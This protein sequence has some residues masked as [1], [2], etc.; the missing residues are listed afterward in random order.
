MSFP[1]RTILDYSER[2]RR[3]YCIIRA[4][5]TG[6]RSTIAKKM[7]V[8]VRSVSNYIQV[9]KSL[10]AE[11]EYDPVSESY[12]FANGFVLTATLEVEIHSD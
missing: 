1:S 7:H 3:L 4:R 12:Y 5:N 9:L 6:P 2:I 8:S 11:I 10:G